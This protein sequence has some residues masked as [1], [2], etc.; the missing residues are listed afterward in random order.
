MSF[1]QIVENYRD[2]DFET[3]FNKLTDEAV[4]RSLAAEKTTVLDFLTLLSPRAEQWLEPMAQKA[5]RLT[6][7][8][9]GRTIQLFIPLY[10]SN[11]CTNHCLY[12]GFNHSNQILRRK[13]TLAEIEL[14]A[15]AIAETGMQHLL[16]LTGEDPRVTSIDYLIDAVSLLKSYFASVSIEV[17]PL[18]IDEYHRLQ[19]AGVDGMTIFQETYDETTYGR[20]HP[21]GRKSDYHWRLNAPE[22]AARGG[23]RLV[24]LGA[25]LG[26]AEPRSEMFLTGL[27]VRYLEN[28][29]LDT[30]VSIS[31][32]R[33]NVAQGHFIPAYMV[34]DRSFV[35]FMT[36]LR[37]FLPRNSLT[38]STRESASFRDQIMPLG[39]TRYSAGSCT[40]VGGYAKHDVDQ[41]PQFEITDNRDV[42][43]VAE[44]IIAHGYQPIYKDWDQIV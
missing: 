13:L 10:L 33:F 39:A 26:L 9:F 40:G 32:P 31:L 8:Y 44:A 27:H 30:E 16:I 35:Q 5:H 4:A 7:Q 3:F 19:Q 20:V 36:A 24:N 15:Q 23:L 41:T 21:A 2:F 1:Y 12:C 14:E 11:H 22:R 17:Y 6:T 43:E 18:E 42:S 38:I 37:I 28:S 34:G 29:F 25:L